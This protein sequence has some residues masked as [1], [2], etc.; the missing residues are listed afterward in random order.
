MVDIRVTEILGC[1]RYYQYKH[2]AYPRLPPHFYIIKGKLIH[3]C[4][5]KLFKGQSLP[6]YEKL[7]REFEVEAGSYL[8]N[9]I[10][11]TLS[12]LLENLERWIN[13]TKI[14]LSPENILGVELE[15]RMP[16]K[17]NFNLAIDYF[18]VCHI[19]LI[20]KTHIIDFKSGNPSKEIR[21]WQQLGAYREHAIYEGL[22]DQ[23]LYGD[24]KLLNVFLGGSQ[25]IEYGPTLDQVTKV[26]PEFYRRMFKLIEVDEK[27]R[28]VDNYMAPCEVGW[29]CIFCEQRHECRGV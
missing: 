20:T 22:Q 5:E 11:G 18:R 28:S 24:W 19:D 13:T 7:L 16:I 17:E 21:Y 9:A 4:I 6:D 1:P 14:D 10:L 3:Y 26:M 8:E 23:T 29:N 25:P 12:H 15:L 27:I 2:F